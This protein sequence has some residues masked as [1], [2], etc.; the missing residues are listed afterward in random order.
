MCAERCTH[1]SEGGKFRKGRTYPVKRSILLIKVQD[2]FF[3]L[4]AVLPVSCKD[5]AAKLNPYFISGFSD[6]ESSF[7]IHIRRKSDLKIK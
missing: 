2:L 6:A 3:L 4:S 7:R 5:V 1:G